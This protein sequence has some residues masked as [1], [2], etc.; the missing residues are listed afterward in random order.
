MKLGLAAA[1]AVMLIMLWEWFASLILAI[2]TGNDCSMLLWFDAARWWWD[3][4]IWEKPWWQANG[5]WSLLVLIAGTVPT[6]VLLVIAVNLRPMAWR[7][8]KAWY[9]I[10][11]NPSETPWDGH[12]PQNT[13]GGARFAE[14]IGKRM[15][16]E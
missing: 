3:N 8:W 9:T 2:L 14:W 6:A 7:A 11:V 15:R 13:H 10:T 16:D 4:V 12:Q 1:L 5:D